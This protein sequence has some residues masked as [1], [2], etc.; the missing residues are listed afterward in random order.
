MKYLPSS[1]VIR[2]WSL[3]TVVCS[4]QIWQSSRLR[5]TIWVP[6][7]NSMTRPSTKLGGG[8]G[9]VGQR[10]KRSDGM[11]VPGRNAGTTADRFELLATSARRSPASVEPSDAPSHRHLDGGA[12]DG[13]RHRPR[14]AWHRLQPAEANHRDVVVLG[15]VAGVLA[16]RADQPL[17]RPLRPRRGHV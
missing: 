12:G 16:D 8:G 7:A 2:A 1:P 15:P 3:L 11:G 9:S 13:P 5:P 17:A 10:S 6:G 14:G 4:M